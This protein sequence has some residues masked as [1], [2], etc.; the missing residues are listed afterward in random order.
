M[1]DISFEALEVAQVRDDEAALLVVGRKSN[2]A[3][4]HPLFGEER[5]YGAVCGALNAGDE[6]AVAKG[7]VVPVETTRLRGLSLGALP[8][9]CSRHNSPAR[10]HAVTKVV[11][12]AHDAAG[13]VAILVDD[14]AHVGACACAVARALPL[15]TRKSLAAAAAAA[16]STTATTK[17]SLRVCFFVV[18]VDEIRPAKADLRACAAVVHG[19]RQCA[20]IVDTPPADMTTA[21]LVAE[22][23]AVAARLGVA[24]SVIQGERALA[25]NGL[26]CIWGVGKA[27]E[28]PPAL[29]V[30]SHRR[31]PGGQAAALVGKGIVYDTGGLALKSK[32]GMCGMKADL[33]GAAAVLSA[34]EAAVTTGS[35]APYTALHCL[36][37]VAE[38]AIGP[39]AVRNDDILVSLSGKS[40]E[41]NNTDAEGRLVL[42][43]GVAYASTPG[44]F[45]EPVALVLEAATLTGAQMVSTGKRIA[46]LCCDDD[47]IEAR[48]VAA[49]LASGDLARPLPFIPE[50]HKLEF[51]SAVADMKNSVKDRLNA[52]CSCAATFIYQ[53]RHADYAGA[54][55]HV[56]LA[57][58]AFNND[59]ATG[60][61]VALILALLQ[62]PPFAP[63]S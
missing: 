38:N 25:E 56:D 21:Q 13:I 51:K 41:I 48:A 11:A 16:G 2:L 15:F 43:D 14:D 10:P 12:E 49:G 17:K 47:E 39:K 61:G 19:V 6:G 55:L 45:D 28:L 57:G 40:I 42:A 7:I 33:G 4:A 52:Q 35:Y 63:T 32:E 37:C 54:W 27:A 8:E 18:A 44:R 26:G 29:V 23:Q 9:A 60:Y 30:L 46:A 31:A 34:F 53:H 5:V 24:I 22:A 50:W 1:V 36:L 62:A 20:R 59:R 58:P 3:G